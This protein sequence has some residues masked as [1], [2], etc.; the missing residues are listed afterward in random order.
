MT[1]I[2]EFNNL[3]LMQTVRNNHLN[4]LIRRIENDIVPTIAQFEQEL[5][6]SVKTVTLDNATKIMKF[7]K[8]IGGYK[9]IDLKPIIPAW[10]GIGVQTIDGGGPSEGVDIVKFPDATVTQTGKVAVVGFDWTSVFNHNQK[11]PEVVL[12]GSVS[13]LKSMVFTGDT[14]AVTV[15]GE[16]VTLKIPK[17]EPLLV[18][19]PEGDPVVRDPTPVTAI[20]VTGEVEGNVIN[21]GVLTL[22]LNAGGGAGITNQNF[23]GFYDSLGD[24]QRLVTDPK[25][26]KSF[27]FAKDSTLG[28]GYYTPYFYVNSTW[29]KLQ[30][31]PALTY[32]APSAATNQGVF[33]IKPNPGITI[34]PSGQLDLGGLS[35]PQL[36]QYFVGFYENLEAL[37]AACP[38]PVINQSFGY[39]K[40]QGGGWLNYR[41]E[42][43]GSATLWKIVAP[44]GSFSFVDGS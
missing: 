34:D 5:H 27:A 38:K 29:Q 31:D 36:P 35:T 13:H 20:K 6:E 23:K 28:G 3:D 24:I 11:W 33:S 40:G 42:M 16:N 32:N 19:I 8:G 10:K 21:D 2:Q 9:E 41:A 17:M 22:K 15:S 12:K 44:M 7:D 4:P 1:K 26:G 43:Q 25:D 37:K 14:S 39:A 30:Q 18:T